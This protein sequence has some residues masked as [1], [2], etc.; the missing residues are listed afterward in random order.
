MTSDEELL[1]DVISNYS[2]KEYN[3]CFMDMKNEFLVKNLSHIRGNVFANVAYEGKSVLELF[4]EYGAITDV[5]SRK[6][7]TVDAYVVTDDQLHIVDKRFGDRLNISCNLLA[8]KKDISKVDKTYDIAVISNPNFESVEDLS[9]MLSALITKVSKGGYIYVAIDNKYGLRYFA[10]MAEPNTNKVFAG[11]EGYYGYKGNRCF[12]KNEII[13]ALLGVDCVEAKWY[14]P[15]PD[16]IF[17]MSIYSDDYLP[18]K[19][20]LSNNNWNWGN[21]R[22]VSFDETRVYN[23]LVDDGMFDVFSNSFLLELEV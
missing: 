15:Y 2:E 21:D 13:N 23:S 1:L 9:E 11:I 7:R 14:Y 12:S 20:E 8:D 22:F 16:R 3:K 10:G 17:T 18:K 19:G 4:A 5:L 6:A